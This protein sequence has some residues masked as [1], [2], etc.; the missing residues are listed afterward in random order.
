M[1][2]QFPLSESRAALTEASARDER[3]VRPPL[4]AKHTSLAPNILSVRLSQLACC[5]FQLCMMLLAFIKEKKEHSPH[6]LPFCMFSPTADHGSM[7]DK[8]GTVSDSGVLFLSLW[9]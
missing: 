5:S 9:W 4:G 1:I 7:V 3:V 8:A 6:L 2:F